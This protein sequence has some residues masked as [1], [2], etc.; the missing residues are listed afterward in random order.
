MQDA[1]TDDLIFGI[2]QL[3]AHLSRLM[4]LE[5]GDIVSTGTPSGV[6]STRDPRV[7]LK[8]G[9]EIVDQ[10]A[11]AGA[12]GDADRASKRPRAAALRPNIA[13]SSE[14]QEPHD[15]EVEP[16]RRPELDGDRHRRRERR[17]LGRASCAG[18]RRRRRAP[19]P[20]RSPRSTD[21]RKSSEGAW[22][23]TLNG[24]LRD[25]W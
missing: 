3:V 11:D 25:A 2:P 22:P 19:A 4:T 18:A 13:A 8:P 7:W 16:V 23:Q 21:C 17:D 5:P 1:S 15:V 10:L 20:P 6:G 12:A 24:E 14:R 9:D